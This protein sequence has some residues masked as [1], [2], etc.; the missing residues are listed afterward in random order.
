MLSSGVIIMSLSRDREATISI[1]RELY[2]KTGKET[3]ISIAYERY[4]K[5]HYEDNYPAR[6]TK[7]D[8]DFIV[9]KIIAN[10]NRPKCPDC[11][12]PMSVWEV[13]NHTK[14]MVGGDYKTQW[15]CTDEENCGYQ[16]EYSLLTLEEQVKMYD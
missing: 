8:E 15:V 3:N 14:S 4:L 13:N 10:K 6:I 5:E 1:A 9:L 2:I 16:N 7:R 11:N 12:K